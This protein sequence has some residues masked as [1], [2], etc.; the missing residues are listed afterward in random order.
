MLFERFRPYT[1]RNVRTRLEDGKQCVSGTLLRDGVPAA[2]VEYESGSD[3]VGVEWTN[4]L[5]E[6][7]LRTHVA[8]IHGYVAEHR[9]RDS[10]ACAFILDVLEIGQQVLDLKRWCKKGCVYRLR[11][12]EDGTWWTSDE[13]YSK[14]A[15]DE[16]RD[17]FGEDLIQ[18]ANELPEILGTEISVKGP[19]RPAHIR[20]STIAGAHKSR[21]EARKRLHSGISA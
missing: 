6:L 1:F 8:G 20:P 9:D 14:S 19:M 10:R 18:I 11:Q 12:D 4:A 21:N 2:R 13:P 17:E 7:D 15:A 3:T 16:L 5:Q